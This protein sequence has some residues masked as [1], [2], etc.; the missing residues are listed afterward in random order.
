MK[1]VLIIG[2]TDQNNYKNIGI[3]ATVTKLGYNIFVLKRPSTEYWFQE[4]IKPENIICA[5]LHDLS[6]T[7][8]KIALFCKKNHIKFDAI[9]TFKEHLVIQAS[10]IV[11]AFGCIHTPLKDIF[12]SSGNKLLFREKYNQIED[13]DIIKSNFN[14][15]NTFDDL[16]SFSKDKVIKP[17]F[18]SSS[19]GVQKISAGTN[20]DGLK[21]FLSES[22]ETKFKDGHER[23]FLIEDYIAGKAF[24][25]DGIIQNGEIK[26]AGINEYTYGPLPYFIQ[27]GNIIPTTLNED[28]QG[29]CYKSVAKIIDHFGYNNCPFH[30]E[31]I[32]KDSKVY[33]I[34]IACRMPGGKIPRGYE[35]AYGFNFIEQVINLYLGKPVNFEQKTQCQVI[36]KGLHV[37]ENCKISSIDIPA[38]VFKEID[39]ELITKPGEYNSYPINN[40]PIYFYSVQTNNFES[41]INKC[42]KIEKSICINKG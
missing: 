36:Q 26:F 38:N 9:L 32:I 34:E 42:K 10:V 33:L 18:G 19:C 27:T 4:F 40:K 25:V 37:F 12:N 7:V 21:Q 35:L 13:D 28:E 31:I 14:I 23:A 39:F 11:Q 24:S 8:S 30:A 20:I 6:D 17:I 5:D 29:L 3:L 16:L 15:I 22:I 2:V 41:A 1:N